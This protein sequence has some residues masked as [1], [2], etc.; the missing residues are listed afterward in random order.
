M[1]NNILYFKWVI[2]NFDG[3]YP[4]KIV[5]RPL[6]REASIEQFSNRDVTTE[7][8]SALQEDY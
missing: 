6:D 7:I 5:M 4:F 3:P 2:E 1:R 8:L